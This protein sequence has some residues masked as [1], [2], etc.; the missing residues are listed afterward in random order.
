MKAA[1]QNCG[2]LPDNFPPLTFLHHGPVRAIYTS[3]THIWPKAPGNYYLLVPHSLRRTNKDS[4]PASSRK[5]LNLLVVLYLL[6]PMEYWKRP[7][8][9]VYILHLLEMQIDPD[10]YLQALSPGKVDI[11]ARQIL[12]LDLNEY[13]CETNRALMIAKESHTDLGSEKLEGQRALCS[14]TWY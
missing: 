6:I 1:L 14:R 7:S 3:R 4:L 9:K 12:Q 10:Q 5:D 2:H 8:V 11:L 13:N